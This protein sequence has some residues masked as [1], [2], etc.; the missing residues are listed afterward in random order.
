MD[1]QSIARCGDRVPGTETSTGAGAALRNP[2]D[3]RRRTVAEE[4]ALAADE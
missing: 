2:H 1:H 3:E 4:R